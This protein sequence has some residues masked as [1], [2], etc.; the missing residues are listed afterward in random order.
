MTLTQDQR[1]KI[2]KT[3]LSS[4]DAP[5]VDRVDFDV[6]VG[7]VV[8]N[9]IRIAEVPATLVEINPQWRGDEYFVVRDEI[10]I[11]DH[12][13]RI[14]ATVPVG[15]SSASIETRSSTAGSGGYDIRRVQEVLL[16]KGFYHGR[17]DGTFGPETRQ[18]LI[19]FQ[20][21]EGMEASGRID[22]RTYAALGVS[23]RT[24]GRAGPTEEK[25]SSDQKQG[26]AE[27]KGQQKDLNNQPSTSGQA[28]S[29]S[30]S[31][32]DHSL[33]GKNDNAKSNEAGKDNKSG[34]NDRP[35]TSGQAGRAPSTENKASGQPS[36][37]TVKPQNE[38][39]NPGNAGAG[40]KQRKRD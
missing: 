27:P 29:S 16:E 18:A 4:R 32:A 33:N 7:V 3:V 30:K 19:M 2:Q 5:R 17:V 39:A 37:A 22:E 8:P 20:R 21:R 35:S 11:I 10:V 13:R 31:P 15:S 26:Q 24:E 34:Q 14:V 1:S 38:P 9:R 28:G 12:G 36:G 40:D 23:G 25:G 6:N